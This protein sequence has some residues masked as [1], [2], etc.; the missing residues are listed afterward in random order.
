MATPRRKTSTKAKAR[1]ST[2]RRRATPKA[3]AKVKARAKAKAKAKARP[4]QTFSVSHHREE[5][6]AEGL[7]S[8]A[9]YRDL[10]MSRSTEGMVQ[11]HVIR[12]VP[13]CRPEEVSKRHFHDVE[14]QM[15]YVLKGW[16]KTELEGQ[17]AI[18]ME[19]GSCW[20]Q[21]P[22]IEHVVLDYSDDCEVLEVIIPAEFETVT[23]E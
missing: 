8:Y 3:K 6:F 18:T 11:A 14:F 1:R 9:K 10:G 22:R 12:F 16:I 17:G 23:L 15:V 21:P 7:R 2:A 5:D 13:P 20:I 4:R 19:A